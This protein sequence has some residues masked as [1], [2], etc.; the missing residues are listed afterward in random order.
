M[1]TTSYP[2]RP[3][4]VSG[5][6]IQRLVNHLP[7]DVKVTI[8]TPCGTQPMTIP[9]QKNRHVI[10]FRYA[11]YS[12]QTL[13]H[14]PGGLPV[15]F[16]N[17]PARLLLL[18]PFLLSLFWN[19]LTTARQADLIHA[20]WSVVGIVAGL[21]GWITSRPVITTLRG[22][23][24]NRARSSILYR[25]LFKLCLRLNQKIVTVS[26]A[27]AILLRQW[28]PNR[29][30]D[31]V[32][33]PNGLDTPLFTPSTASPPTQSEPLL[34]T[35]GSLIPRK[36]IHLILE[37][38][39]TLQNLHRFRLL[40]VGNGPEEARLRELTQHHQLE[41]RVTF[42]GQVAPEGVPALLAQADIFLLASAGEGRANVV[43]EAMA[44]GLPIIA[45]QIEGMSELVHHGENGLLFDLEDPLSL[46]Q[47]IAKLLKYPDLA[48]RMG[49]RGRELIQSWG[50]DWRATATRYQTLWAETLSCA[51]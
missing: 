5:I 49:E 8:I 39:A 16:K 2:L 33:I 3:D 20:N 50:V 30:Q 47:C 11:P 35:V 25:L 23:D 45:S 37:A 22:E 1:V 10:E 12:W 21:A 19:I 9:T 7:E 13:A 51:D 4:S 27:F 36:G 24:I 28:E 6:F 15:A 38:L 29:S 40:V 17:H 26:D 32:M 43:L 42:H 48:H 46:P 31:I 44:M 41:S 34:I 14:Q 18:P